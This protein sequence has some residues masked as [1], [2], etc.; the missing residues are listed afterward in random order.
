MDFRLPGIIVFRRSGRGEIH[1]RIS[2][3]FRGME[4][5]IL[6]AF[7]KPSLSQEPPEEAGWR[8][9][10]SRKEAPTVPGPEDQR[11]LNTE[12][13]KGPVETRNRV[14]PLLRCGQELLDLAVRRFA[15]QRR[16]T[17]RARQL[18]HSEN[19]INL[20]PQKTFFTHRGLS[21]HED[22]PMMQDEPET[23]V[24]GLLHRL[25]LGY[26]SRHRGGGVL[27]LDPI[28]EKTVAEELIDRP[29]IVIDD[30]FAGRQPSACD[31]G[32][33]FGGKPFR[34]LSGRLDVSQE[35]P[36][37]Q[38]SDF[39]DGFFRARPVRSGRPFRPGM[40]KSEAMLGDRYLVAV[41]QLA[42]LAHSS[43]VQIGAIAAP[44]IH[45][46]ILVLSLG[47]NHRMAA[48][49]LFSHEHNRA[50]RR[51]SEDARPAD[52]RLYALAGS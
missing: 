45:Q 10:P 46:P 50:I 4:R 42:G 36:A 26:G 37:V 31:P 41:R 44:Q 1:D 11:R 49:N 33:L 24:G 9:E 2:S 48:R 22:L 47:V 52:R 15:E 34:E 43:S 20:V 8:G 13:E 29:V 17:D 6:F 18:F 14:T 12:E 23:R 39:L 5:V 40:S 28:S 19:E 21:S 25:E 30:L 32:R 7:T 35:K 3:C 38:R 51:S 16:F 27:A